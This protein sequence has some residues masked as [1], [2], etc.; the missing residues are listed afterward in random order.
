MACLSY[1]HWLWW[2][3]WI[4]GCLGQ[5]TDCSFL[6]QTHPEP[7]RG[8]SH[9]ERVVYLGGMKKCLVKKNFNYS[10]KTNFCSISFL[11]LVRFRLS[12]LSK[13]M[14]HQS[15]LPE[16]K[17]VVH[18]QDEVH[19]W[20]HRDPRVLSIPLQCDGAPGPGSQPKTARVFKWLWDGRSDRG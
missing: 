10:K 4:P 12:L 5:A 14:S 2:L 8:G 20:S 11:A 17:L 3:F 9:F 6:S 19:L 7:D 18:T 1:L 15:S 13:T 16:V